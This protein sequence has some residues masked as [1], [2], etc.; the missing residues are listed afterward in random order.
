MASIR[1]RSTLRPKTNA[2]SG[3]LDFN[4]KNGATKV[5]YP[6]LAVWAAVAGAF[7]LLVTTFSGKDSFDYPASAALRP[8]WNNQKLSVEHLSGVGHGKKKTPCP[9]QYK[10]KFWMERDKINQPVGRALRMQGWE[11]TD[12]YQHAQVIWTYTSTNKWYDKLE[13]WQRYNH[14]PK[15]KLFNQK[16]SFVTYMMAYSDK[17][18]Q[19]LPAIPETY[20]L[21]V[22]SDLE[23][24]RHRLFKDGGLKIPWVLKK[25]KVNQGKGITM[26]GP[27]TSELKNVLKTVEAEKDVQNYII[28]RY[29]CN[30]MTINN[31]K[32]DFR[33]FFFV[34]SLDPLIIMY[35]DG[36]LR[37]GNSEYTEQDFSNTKAHLTTHTYLA[38]EGKAT[39]DQ[40]GEYLAD[41]VKNNEDLK[42]IKNPVL[43]VTNQ[44]KHVLAEMAAAFKESTF[45]ADLISAE[46]G[47]AFYGADFIIDWDLDVF[48]IEPQHGCG[49]DE[50]HQFRVEMH[51]SLFTSMITVTEE[52]WER[53]ERGLPT[54][55]SSIKNVG[56][57]Q[58]V[59]NDDWMFKY[60]GYVRSKN[61]R[62]C[63][64]AKKK[65]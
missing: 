47:F 26:L 10:K 49:L 64:I 56:P 34:V 43:H 11:K 58:C 54:D 55:C 33:V 5:P 39:W 8:Q 35:H 63:E 2:T 23:K 24:F 38:S 37:L 20:R 3:N 41:A 60:E 45:N 25:P 42:H 9:P 31:K 17:I 50:D 62:G 36:Y 27:N 52:I 46:N 65:L 21:D 7:L 1:H 18:G 32:F 12:D 4:G 40:F 57:L 48:F 14:L 13:P 6:S 22:E 29:V 19:E 53:Q 61:K 51:N 30:E 28:Q 15:Y 44:V 16:D 59:Y